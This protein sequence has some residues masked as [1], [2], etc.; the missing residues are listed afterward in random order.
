MGG[1]QCY[2]CIATTRLFADRDIYADAAGARCHDYWLQQPAASLSCPG[3]SDADGY[4]SVEGE[5]SSRFD[6]IPPSV[7]DAS[8]STSTIGRQVKR[9]NDE[10]DA[11]WQQH[12]CH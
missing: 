11:A 6:V 9:F 4:S 3:L 12:H 5:T 1:L 7:D 2:E 10:Y 8:Q